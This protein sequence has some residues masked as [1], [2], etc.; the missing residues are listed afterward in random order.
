M[1]VPARLVHLITLVVALGGLALQTGLVVS[2]AALPA[3]VAPPSE[4]VRLWRLSS[5]FTIQSNV[6]VAVM[7][8]TLVRDVDRDGPLWRVVRGATLVGITVTGLVHAVLLRP[9]QDL[10]GWTAFADNIQHVAVPLLAVIGW[11]LAGPRPRLDPRSARLG[12]LWPVIWLVYTFVVAAFTGFY[13]YPFLDADEVGVL[14]VVAA[15]AGITLLFV[16]LFGAF[17]ALD[18]RLPAAPTARVSATPPVGR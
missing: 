6:L 14:G 2:G 16:L 4:A 1:P 18:R 15:C 8:F 9:L 17:N 5:Y 13:P 7:A 11:V 3:D 10:Q 12:L